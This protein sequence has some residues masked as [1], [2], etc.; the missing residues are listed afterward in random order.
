MDPTVNNDEKAGDERNRKV[1]AVLGQNEPAPGREQGTIASEKI[2]VPR[3]IEEL[4]FRPIDVESRQQDF[5]KNNKNPSASTIIARRKWDNASNNW[6][7]LLSDTSGSLL[8]FKDVNH[9]AKSSKDEWSKVTGTKITLD[10][11][12]VEDEEARKKLVALEFQ[13]GNSKV[14]PPHSDNAAWSDLVANVAPARPAMTSPNINIEKGRTLRSSTKNESGMKKKISNRTPRDNRA[15]D[16]THA[17]D[18]SDD[19]AASD[20]SRAPCN[21][22]IAPDGEP[23]SISEQQML[24][25]ILARAARRSSWWLAKDSRDY[26]FYGKEHHDKA[27]AIHLKTPVE[28]VEK[29][30]YPTDQEMETVDILLRFVGDI[31]TP[32]PAPASTGKYEPWQREFSLSEAHEQRP[33]INPTQM[34]GVLWK[35]LEGQV[36]TKYLLAA[37]QEQRETLVS[38]IVDQAPHTLHENSWVLLLVLSIGPKKHIK[39]RL[40]GCN[41]KVKGGWYERSYQKLLA[42]LKESLVNDVP[43]LESLDMG[44]AWRALK[45]MIH[46]EDE[47]PEDWTD[48]DTDTEMELE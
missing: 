10:L 37:S 14:D 20:V 43:R 23:G 7:Y 12:K 46:G 11:F 5:L 18:D 33:Q 25:A 31:D 32:S 22:P 9:V 41:I 6:Q 28:V 45:E 27:N 21:Y 29:F 15:D 4:W 3:E 38:L 34:F 30:C 13:I 40:R 24:G 1:L 19:S 2:Q 42:Q 47:D 26:S 48:E 8:W 39:R 35:Q 17:A 36:D 44:A 16:K